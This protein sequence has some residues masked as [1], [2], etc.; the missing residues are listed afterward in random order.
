M[1]VFLQQDDVGGLLGDVHGR[2]HRDADVRHMQRRGVIDAIAEEADHMA[3]A[4]EQAHDA[5][6]VRGRE[7]GKHRGGLGR[8]SQPRIVQWPPGPNPA[9]PRPDSRPT[10]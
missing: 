6:L 3:V 9:T 2:V 8:G 7:F 10:S 5:L 1:Q 4:L